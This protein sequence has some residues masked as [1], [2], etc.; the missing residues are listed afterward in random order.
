VTWYWFAACANSVE[1]I[2]MDMR[3]AQSVSAL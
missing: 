2:G 1:D 3:N